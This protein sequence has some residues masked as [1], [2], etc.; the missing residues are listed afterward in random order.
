[1]QRKEGIP[2]GRSWGWPGPQGKS[3]SKGHGSS[4]IPA[5]L[6]NGE[7]LKVVQEEA[8]KGGGPRGDDPDVGGACI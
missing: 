8:Y 6:G 7:A 5:G 3:F 4:S 2:G 1:V